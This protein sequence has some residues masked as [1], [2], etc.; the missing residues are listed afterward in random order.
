MTRFSNTAVLISGFG[1]QAAACPRPADPLPAGDGLSH[2]HPLPGD[3]PSGP[4]RV[5]ADT[6]A[7][8]RDASRGGLSAEVLLCP[9]PF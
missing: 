8:H 1:A 4:D 2:V 7:A 6:H 5:A 3:R 9:V